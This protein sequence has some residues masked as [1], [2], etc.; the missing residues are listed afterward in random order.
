M[1]LFV[2]LLSLD[3]TNPVHELLHK[4]QLLVGYD[5][6]SILENEDFVTVASV[7]A[8]DEKDIAALFQHLK[9]GTLKRLRQCIEKALQI[10]T[11]NAASRNQAVQNQGPDP[12]T[13]KREKL[14]LMA[15]FIDKVLMH[16]ISQNENK[17]EIRFPVF[18]SRMHYILNAGGVGLGIDGF[19]YVNGLNP[20]V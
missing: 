14:I 9:R 3:D 18:R 1:K 2:V 19:R 7:A 10:T 5:I 6:A 20:M 16:C 15:V 11:A 13:N 8:I 4:H 12:W 17:E